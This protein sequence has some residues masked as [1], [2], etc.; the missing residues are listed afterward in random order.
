VVVAF[1]EEETSFL[2]QVTQ[3]LARADVCYWIVPSLFEHGFQPAVLNGFGEV[4]VIEVKVDPLDQVERLF[5]RGLDITLATAGLLFGSPLLLAIALAILLESGWP[6]LYLQERVG[7]N[8]RHFQMI[9]YRTMTKDAE[10]QLDQMADMNEAGSSLIFK[11]REDPRVTRVGRFLRRSSLD[12]LPQFVN[13]LRGEM[14]MVGPRPPLPHE[15]SQYRPEHF[16][17]LRCLPGITGL[18]QVSG[19]S[20]VSFEDMVR[21][22]R[23][24]LEN[25]SVKLDLSIVAKTFAAVLRREGAY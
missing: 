3:L 11:M 9:K 8:G 18:W 21:L 15:V 4:P 22:D 19:R 13:V 1:D 2:P 23:Y 20:N 25:W 17:R 10:R 24:Y 7:K 14:S 5:K 12:E 16:V 6:V